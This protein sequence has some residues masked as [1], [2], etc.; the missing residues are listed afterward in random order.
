[1]IVYKY[2]LWDF[3][4]LLT[5]FL[6]FLTRRKYKAKNRSPTSAGASSWTT[7]WK[8]SL[9]WGFLWTYIGPFPLLEE[10][11][12]RS[13][14]HW[15]NSSKIT[16]TVHKLNINKCSKILFS[17]NVFSAQ[18]A[19]TGEHSCMVLKPLNTDDIETNETE[20]LGFFGP[21]YKGKHLILFP[22]VRKML[23]CSRIWLLLL[24][25][26]IT[27]YTDFNLTFLCYFQIS[28]KGL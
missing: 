8:A 14:L 21:F 11:W 5:M 7:T 17:I 24:L 19:M 28:G 22:T 27:K 12:F 25:S 10:T 9:P 13:F 18:N 15:P 1:M 6:G 20:Q 3:I 26:F 16:S 2:M 4:L 23:S